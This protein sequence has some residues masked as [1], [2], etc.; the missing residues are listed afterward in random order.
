[1]DETAFKCK[2]GKATT[3]ATTEHITVYITITVKICYTV[4]F[5]C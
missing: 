2:V 5:L 3:T 1:M 4:G